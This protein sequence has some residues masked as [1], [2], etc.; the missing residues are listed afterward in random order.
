MPDLALDARPVALDELLGVA[1]AALQLAL[2]AGARLLDVA[3]ARLA[4][5]RAAALELRDRALGLRGGVADVADQGDRAVAG[6]SV[7][8][9]LTSA[10]RSAMPRP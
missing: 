5:G 1:A 8:P 7:A 4:G 9:T 6:L 2:E 10:A 3:L